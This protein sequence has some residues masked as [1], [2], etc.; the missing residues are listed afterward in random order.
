MFEKKPKEHKKLK[1]IA[2]SF[3]NY[4]S[5]KELGKTGDSFND[6]VTILLRRVTKV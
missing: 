3:E 4:Y 2:I 1:L 6:V 5:L